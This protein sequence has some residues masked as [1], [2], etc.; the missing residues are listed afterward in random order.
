MS[1]SRRGRGADVR[2][3]L[4]AAAEALLNEPASVRGPSRIVRIERAVPAVDLITRL[5]AQSA[6]TKWYW[7]A[8]DNAWAVAGAGI[9]WRCVANGA[10]AMDTLTLGVVALLSE[11]SARVRVYGGLRFDADR[12]VGAA[13][14]PFAAAQFFVPRLEL[15]REGERFTLSCQLLLPDD[16]ANRDRADELRALM[17]ADDEPDADAAF[18]AA[19]LARA[20]TPNRVTWNENVAACLGAFERGEAEKIVLARQSDF[21]AD[22]IVRPFAL[23]RAIGLGT[24]NS[25]HYCFQPADGLA[26]VGASPERLYRRIDERVETEALAGTRPRGATPE[27]DARL[28]AELLASDKEQREHAHV[29]RSI[30]GVLRELCTNIE[31]GAPALLRLGHYQHLLTPLHAELRAGV[32]DGALLSGLHPTPAVGG[33]PRA[34]AIA[35]I[36]EL[37]GFDRGWYTG[38]I[39]WIGRDGAEFAVAIRSALV[40]GPTIS[41]YTGA[42]IVP[43]SDPDAEWRELENKLADFRTVLDGATADTPANAGTLRR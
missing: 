14:Q 29:S 1:I 42:G 28:G 23:L 35:R 22:E 43:G 37:E 20:D 17:T 31:Q 2:A 39:G 6:D 32:D 36:R 19:I 9:A 13:W 16:A 33:V 27:D 15:R 26:F 10:G 18:D 11:S 12:A 24:P 30:G 38:P 40:H 34:T 7:A 5:A 8:R 21:H 41:V 3:E 4:L 25:F